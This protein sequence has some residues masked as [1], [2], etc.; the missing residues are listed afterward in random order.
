MRARRRHPPGV[1]LG[2]DV[3]I[4]RDVRLEAAPGARIVVGDGAVLGDGCVLVALERIEVGDGAVLG[5]G[6]V[7]LDALPAYDDPER[8]VREQGV[9]SAPVRVGPRATLGP[10]A[11]VLA[12]VT[13]GAG[14]RVIAHAVVERDVAPGA[15]VDGVGAAPAR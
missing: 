6:A 7:V 3:A 5:D 8:P 14:A 1:R 4:G 12:G 13:V 9:R 15:V 11:C 10:G 2:R